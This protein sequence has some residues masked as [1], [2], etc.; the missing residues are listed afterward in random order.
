MSSLPTLIEQNMSADLIDEADDN[1]VYFGF[2]KPG[3]N[4]CM[5][6]RM[7]KAG[8]VTTVMYPDG[9]NDFVYDWASRAGYN[10][11]HLR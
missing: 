7:L 6:K 10:Y 11:L 9:I 5:I 8:T 1:T 2:L 3:T 4:N